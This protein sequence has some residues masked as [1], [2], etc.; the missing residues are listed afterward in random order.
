ML[1]LSVS[2]ASLEPRGLSRSLS[3]SALELDSRRSPMGGGGNATP[4]SSGALPQ[5]SAAKLDMSMSGSGYRPPSGCSGSAIQRPSSSSSV[6]K[7]GLGDRT[8][9][10][11]SQAQTRAGFALLEME[12]TVNSSTAGSGEFLGRAK[13][14][15]PQ[16]ED[17]YR[18]QFCG[19]R[20]A[21]EYTK[22]HGEPERHTEA[23]ENGFC[24]ISKVKLKQN[25]YFT[26]W[27]KYRQCED[28]HVFKVRMFATPGPPGA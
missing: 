25:G 15:S 17:L 7:G 21:A 27:R 10:G 14:W 23:D 5:L 4:T 20:D 1:G 12:D 9:P 6:S 8:P 28:K 22:A 3:S 13:A 19:W 24:Y 11:S 2:G 16:V 26:Y 18:L